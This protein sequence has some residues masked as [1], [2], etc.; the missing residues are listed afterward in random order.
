M[1]T[2]KNAILRYNTLDKCFQNFGRKYYFDDLLEVVNSALS[3]Y[4]PASSGIKTRQLRDDIKFM[5]S[6]AGYYAEIEAIPDGKKYYYRYADRDFSINSSPLNSTEAEQ[7]KSAISVLQRFEGSPEFEWVNELAP[8]LND[9]F[10]LK[11]ESKKVMEFDSNIDYTGHEYITPMFNAVINEVVLTIN[12][13]PFGKEAEKIDFHGY[14]L[15]QY[16][17]RW[18][19]FGENEKYPGSISNLALDRI[20]EIQDCQMN[21]R[22]SNV[23][24]EQ[25]FDDIVGVSKPNGAKVQTVELL[26]SPE[27]APYINTKPIH[28]SQR[29][30]LQEDGYLLIKLDVIPNYE[31]TMKI[32]SFGEKVT[33]LKPESLVKQVSDRIKEA[34][35]HY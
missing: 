1:A 13:Q 19:A 6:E 24:W 31:L 29:P 9:K 10:G 34:A 30:T 3:E 7:L 17:N 8:L 12:Y 16:N 28:L 35:K 33:V 4:D 26:F 32:L 5:K 20:I 23:D 27:Q 21:Y 25:Y 18:F 14:Y 2:N 22:K 15:K 11:D